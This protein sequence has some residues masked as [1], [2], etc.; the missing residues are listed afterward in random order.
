MRINLFSVLCLILLV[1]VKSMA[2]E[3]VNEAHAMFYYQVPF[4]ASKSEQ[5][6]HSFGFR[7]DHTS[8]KHGEM[9]RYQQLM[10]KTAAFDFKMG[11]EGVQGVYVSGVDYLQLYRLARAAEG[12]NGEEDAE[13][14]AESDENGKPNP[15]TKVAGDIGETIDEI[16][17]IIPLGFIIGGAVGV[18]LITG[19]GG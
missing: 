18:V 1:P 16:M 19:A 7:M 12:E 6:K 9:I 8:Y 14:S 13:A 4:S 15:V 2:L 5:K 11:R 17:D 10:N 3:P